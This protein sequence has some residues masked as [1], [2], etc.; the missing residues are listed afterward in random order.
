MAPSRSALA[1]A[2]CAC[3]L[4]W[5]GAQASTVEGDD[6]PKPDRGGGGGGGIGIRIDLGEL[7]GRGR[8]DPALAESGP[9]TPRRYRMDALQI[10]CFLQ[11]DWPL[12]IAYVAAPGTRVELVATAEGVD[13]YRTELALDAPAG[14]GV[15]TVLLRLPERF[16][17]T[18]RKGNIRISADGKTPFQLRGLGAGPLA[19]GS[20]AIGE[21]RFEP[22]QLKL[23]EGGA[24]FYG[25]HSKS[26]FHHAAVEIL[27]VE[28]AAE[29]FQLTQVQNIAVQQPVTRDGWVG[30]N[31]A[32]SWDG[33]DAGGRASLGPHLLQVRAWTAREGD[34]VIAWSDRNVVVMP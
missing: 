16:G 2:A 1:A 29:R 27:R 28:Y 33:K 8:I 14:A 11:G 3:C 19:V 13:S 22:A 34:W 12:V 17:D 30:R 7:F 5:A 15:Q 18:P 32:L 31:P 20:V 4:A 9:R 26:D 23:R 10:D 24:A 6:H 25:F 21:V